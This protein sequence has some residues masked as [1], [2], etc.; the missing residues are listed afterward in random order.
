ML[1][2][3]V[4]TCA[5]T[6][7]AATREQHPQLPY[8]P[9]EIAESAL[10][11]AE[12]GAAIAHIH[13]R[14]PETGKAS[15]KLDYYREVVERIRAGNPNLLISLTTG[16]GSRFCPSEDD[17]K[18]AAPG[19]S[20]TTPEIRAQHIT[21][22][23]PDIASLNFNTM[24]FGKF[25]VLNTQDHARKIARIIRAAGVRPEIELFDSGDI[26]FAREM[27]STGEV[28]GPGQFSLVLGVKYGFEATTEAMMYARSLLPPGCF[29]TG[30]GTG[31]AGF[32]MAV[33]SWLLGG[34]IRIGLE[35]SL[36]LRKGVLAPSNAAMVAQIRDIL[37]QFGTEPANVAQA[38][39][40][41]G[42][43]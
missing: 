4:I 42:L 3:V 6:G 15:M 32:P 30:F 9:E 29:W 5:V 31:R 37:K 38:R 33:Q 11:A 13:V 22:L 14:D 2:K 27:I 26:H 19:T 21:A 35:D 1:P 12:E 20:L 36:Q 41:L 25:P 23:K 28:A 8:S 10:L 34:H 18:V 39:Q 43:A 24:N 40:L 16:P 7:N 17:P